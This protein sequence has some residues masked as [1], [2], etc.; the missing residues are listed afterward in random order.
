[1]IEARKKMR[2]S[3]IPGQDYSKISEEDE[4]EEF[5]TVVAKAIDAEPKRYG[6]LK[7]YFANRINKNSY[8]SFRDLI[9][10]VAVDEEDFYWINQTHVTVNEYEASADGFNHWY[11]AAILFKGSEL[12]IDLSDEDVVSVFGTGKFIALA[13]LSYGC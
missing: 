9:E 3:M 12:P 5:G 2:S 4:Y 10:S 1:M 6:I 11:D 13:D 8:N 7:K